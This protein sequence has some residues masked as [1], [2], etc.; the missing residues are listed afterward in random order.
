MGKVGVEEI[1][2]NTKD[3]RVTVKGKAADAV[4]VAERVRRKTGRH[5]EIISPVQKKQQPEKKPEVPKVTEVVLKMHL[6]CEGC[7]KDVKHCI[8]KMEGVQTVNPDMEKSLVSVKGAFDPKNLVAYISKR[9]GRHAE[10]VNSKNTNNK[11]KDG[12]QK[13]GDQKNEKKEKDKDAKNAVPWACLR[14]TAV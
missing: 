13:D 12:E 8:H 11:Q 4:K 14:A 10:I 5:V 1:E 6:H 7:A 3:D 2:L 9:A